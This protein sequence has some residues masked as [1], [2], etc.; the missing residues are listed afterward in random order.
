VA[1]RMDEFAGKPAA[2][3]AGLADWAPGHVHFTDRLHVDQ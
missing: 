2:Q 1:V 3:L